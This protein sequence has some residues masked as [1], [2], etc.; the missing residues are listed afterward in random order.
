MKKNFSGIALVTMTSVLC[1][2]TPAIG[3]SYSLDLSTS[4][5][6]ALE[7]NESYLIAKKEL[8]RAKSQIV[9]AAA[10]AMPQIT[11]GLT[12]LRNWKV[13]T[14]VFQFGDEIVTVKFG[15]DNSYTAD[16]TLTQPLYSGGRTIA[17]IKIARLYRKLS[18]EIVRQASQDLK[19]E[20]YNAFF[21]AILAREIRRVSSQSLELA[22]ENLE[23]V[24]KMYEQ[25]VASEYDLLRARVEVAN[26]Q[27]TVTRAET[28]FEVATSALKNLLGIGPENELELKVEFDSTQFIIPPID[29]SGFEDEL[30]L[31][32]PEVKIS[33]YT[34]E[35]RKKA[36]S[37]YTA[38]YKP[39]L[40]F[41]TTLQYQTQFD[42]GNVFER[43]WDRSLSSTLEL[44]IPIFDSW[45]TPSRVKQAR[46]DYTQSELQKEAIRKA[47]ILDLEQSY[48]K[49]LEARVNLSAQGNAVE[50]ARRGLEIANVRFENG[51]GTQLEVS[52]ARLQLQLAEINNA[53]AFY[54]LAVGY[55][56]LMRALGRD[57]EPIR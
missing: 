18:R 35:G 44:N 37:L 7:N 28:D 31:N 21:G 13:P 12:Y 45:K 33:T 54:D 27:P 16:L 9:E 48:G 34:S 6:L 23:V 41:R 56:K 19:V 26:L 52:D 50:L 5:N 47:M 53:T 20:V 11:G 25:G 36:I 42:E 38:G 10:G 14:G 24:E 51:V 1:L 46:I 22:R 55:A 2:I 32:R 3:E 30:I 17:A 49:Y 15:T 57:L 4:I 40:N 8:E 39:S 29:I 43:R